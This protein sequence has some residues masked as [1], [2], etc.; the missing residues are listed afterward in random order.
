MKMNQK[1]EHMRMGL[2]IPS[3]RRNYNKILPSLWIRCLQMI[4]F[5]KMLGIEVHLNNPFLKYDI[6]IFYRGVNKNSYY[7]IHYLKKISG[8]VFWDTV[9]NYY[10]DHQFCNKEQFYYAQKISETVDRVIVSSAYIGQYAR[11]YNNIHYMPDPVNFS[12]FKYFK[13]NISYNE[14]VYGW[15]GQISKIDELVKYKNKINR[16]IAISNNK[17]MV[18]RNFIFYKWRY[19]SFPYLITLCDIG[20]FP[21]DTSNIYNLGHSSFKILVYAAQGL[22]IVTNKIP[23]YLEVNEFYDSIC[24][25]EDHI[26]LENSVKYL[27]DKSRNVEKLKQYF[28]CENCAKQLYEKIKVS[29]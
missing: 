19:E 11:K 3:F 22:P 6:S 24:F 20:L 21:R 25:F 13:K 15:S 17:N 8:K 18:A 1:G 9:V 28:S 10:V 26:T 4:E 7:F 27:S 16:L 12:H 14:P 23:S 29:L 5:Y 2:F